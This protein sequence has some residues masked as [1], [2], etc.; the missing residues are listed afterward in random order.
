MNGRSPAQEF[1]SVLER[2]VAALHPVN[3]PAL[4]R[5]GRSV[6]PR[7]NQREAW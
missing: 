7:D 2:G 1:F 3:Q 5:W 4:K 6:N